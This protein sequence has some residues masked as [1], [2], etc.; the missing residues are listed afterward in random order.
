M[1]K[2]AEQKALE[3]YPKVENGKI[4]TSTFGVI[5]VDKYAPERK[6]FQKGYEQAEKDIN[7]E[8]MDRME[9]YKEMQEKALLADH[10]YGIHIDPALGSDYG[11]VVVYNKDKIVNQLTI[12]DLELLH[13]FLYAVKNNKHGA[14]TLKKLSHE[15][16]Q[17]VLNSFNK[18]KEEK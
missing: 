1:S 17:E 2:R 6:A 9:K 8:M 16:Y 10:N 7:K 12:Q 4:W 15:Q 18:R 5:E 14:F 11:S 3:A 13:T